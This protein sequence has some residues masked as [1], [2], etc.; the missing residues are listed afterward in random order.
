M[1]RLQATATALAI[2]LLAG[3]A[4]ATAEDL[5]RRTTQMYVLDD[6]PRAER[7]SVGVFDPH[8]ELGR[9]FAWAP[10]NPGE[11][12]DAEGLATGKGKLT[13]RIGGSA[14]YDRAAV[15]STY[16]GEMARGRPNGQGRLTVRDG[17]MME[18]NWADGRLEGEGE[19]VDAAGNRYQGAFH[20]GL[21]EGQGRLYLAN[22]NI[23][24]GAFKVGKR[25]GEGTMRLAGGGTYKGRWADDRF[26]GIIPA[27]LPDALAGGLTATASQGGDAARV[28]FGVGVDR[29]VTEQDY[30]FRFVSEPAENGLVIRPSVPTIWERWN[31]KH[32]L[33]IEPNWIDFSEWDYA[34]TH[35]WLAGEIT[36]ADG[37]PF[38]LK[39]IVVD[40]KSSGVFRRPLF[41]LGNPFGCVGY[42]PDL[43]ILN[44]G[45]GKAYNATFSFAFTSK[46]GRARSRTFTRALGM[47][48]RGTEIDL[49]EF[50]QT[51]GVDTAWLEQT[52][53]IC[54]GDKG[55]ESDPTSRM[56]LGELARLAFRADNSLN[57]NL[58]PAGT[59][60]ADHVI[61][62][63]EGR[64]D[65]EWKGDGGTT[66]KASEPV[67]TYVPLGVTDNVEQ[68]AEC[69]GFGGS[70]EA[71]T[72]QKVELRDR[73]KDYSITLP[74]RG[75][76]SLTKYKVYIDLSAPR[77]SVHD[78]IL[79]ARFADGS[80]R[81]SRPLF[82]KYFRVP[83]KPE[84]LGGFATKGRG[85]KGCYITKYQAC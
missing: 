49:S 26:T 34:N 57:I 55:C 5:L 84:D 48:G 29:R 80:V 18:G 7:R 72:Y 12:A 52:R 74:V 21:P 3:N 78:I 39:E 17:S 6:S 77:H 36:V 45:E 79:R 14:D 81:S 31:G 41:A 44:S 68:I 71:P 58:G 15:H 61:V 40:V 19:S 35:V 50:L 65:Y 75:Q 60:T 23:Y 24:E 10:E 27:D 70:P 85:D 56:R 32:T 64:L 30:D 38:K 51:S 66:F 42:R 11:P 8:P 46:D 47:I 22:G 28:E 63:L 25:D 16:E 76:K 83:E 62:R 1:R 2:I 67:E 73:G 33:H 82:L 43:A 53:Y 69:G 59:P 37:K 54:N 13:W 20:E 9:D 4:P